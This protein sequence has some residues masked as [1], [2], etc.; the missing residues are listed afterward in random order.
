MASN[1]ASEFRTCGT[2]GLKV[3]LPAERLF[4]VNAVT[5]VVALLVGGIMA[6]LIALTRWPAVHLLPAD[7]F[8][9]F[10]TAHGLNMLVFWIVFFEMAGLLFASTAVLGSRLPAPWFGWLNF[11]LMLVGALITNYMVFMGQA[12]VLF[13]SYPPLKA[14]PH[15]YLGIILFAVGTLLA[16]F[17]FMA[18]L[19]IAKKE[20]YH[21]GSYPL[22][23]F[24]IL[25]AVI[26][27][28]FTLLMGAATYLPTWLWAMG[29]IDGINPAM[30]RLG[31]WGFGHSAQQI[32]LAAM[33][34]IWYLIGTLSVGAVPINEKFSRGAF[35]LYLLGINVASVHHLLVDPG[36]SAT[37]RIFNT[38]YIL[39]AATIGS[40]I[41]AF[42]IPAAIEVAQR[43]KGFTNGM[44]EWLTKAPWGNP[45][46]AGM[47]L[48]IVIFGFGG[49]VTGVTQ[50]VEQINI[51]SHNTLRIPGHFHV[52]VVGGTTLAFMALTFYVLPLVMRRELI[53]KSF[54][55]YQPWIFAIGICIMST[56]M[57]FAG[58]LGVP[59]RHYDVTFSSAIFQVPFSATATTMLGLLGLGA[60][61]AFTGLLIFCL[62][63]ALTAFFGKRIPPNMELH[64]PPHIGEDSAS[65]A[66]A[67]A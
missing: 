61:I 52:T 56:G 51:M 48:S 15:Y 34:S 58:I 33:V 54:A 44:F 30:Y 21:K 60:I 17:H 57:S 42:S 7:L 6:I 67:Q 11:C 5:A 64:H 35:L 25:I 28:I 47:A 9:R 27:A 31:F 50:G 20:G 12:D 18:T 13:T 3:H 43:A 53:G 14:H 46:F 66:P 1:Y 8:Y 38:S 62:I 65:V 26:L 29:L 2:T 24:G 16:C 19:V 41:H 40:M 49:G 37:Y 23:T 39:Y 10:L 32:N 4:Y 55:K 59:R 22:F 45:A 36:L 63:A